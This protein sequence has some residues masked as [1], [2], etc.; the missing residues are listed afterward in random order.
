MRPSRYGRAIAAP[1]HATNDGFALASIFLPPAADL[2][3]TF[4][5][6]TAAQVPPPHAS[7][8]PG[9]PLSTANVFN[10]ETLACGSVTSESARMRVV[11]SLASR[12]MLT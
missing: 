5:A 4:P 8:T 3:E 9:L 2:N 12:S 11:I 10:V 7:A 1:P 6:A